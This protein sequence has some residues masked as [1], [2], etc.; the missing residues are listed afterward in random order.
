M[1]PEITASLPYASKVFY[2]KTNCNSFAVLTGSDQ[3]RDT[4]FYQNIYLQSII[5]QNSIK[6][7]NQY[8]AYTP[9]PDGFLM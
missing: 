7:P 9:K 3:F 1:L 2:C 8:F 4:I 6:Q 5:V